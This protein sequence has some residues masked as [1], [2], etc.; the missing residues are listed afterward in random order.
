MSKQNRRTYLKMISPAAFET[1]K[2]GAYLC[3]FPPKQFSKL[4]TIIILT[5]FRMTFSLVYLQCVFLICVSLSYCR[6]QIFC[7]IVC[8]ETEKNHVP[9]GN[10]SLSPQPQSFSPHN[11]DNNR[12]CSVGSQKKIN[13]A[14][15]R[16]ELDNL[17]HC[18]AHFHSLNGWNI[19]SNVSVFLPKLSSNLSKTLWLDLLW[20]N[21]VVEYGVQCP[22]S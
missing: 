7:R 11:L 15:V 12:F 22:D 19:E 10:A 3:V 8:R 13:H 5:I 14:K 2:L 6:F 18:L 20:K 4:M 1:Q 21:I 9:L 16:C 17:Q